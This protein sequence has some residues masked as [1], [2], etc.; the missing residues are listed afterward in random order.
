MLRGA[1][2][3]LPRDYPR[4]TGAFT[5]SPF[6]PSRFSMLAAAHSAACSSAAIARPPRHIFTIRYPP[7]IAPMRLP[8]DS[9]VFCSAMPFVFFD[10]FTPFHF[11]FSQQPLICFF[12][13]TPMPALVTTPPAAMLF[14]LRRCAA[15]L[16]SFPPAAEA[17]L[18]PPALFIAALPFFRHHELTPRR[19]FFCPHFQFFSRCFVFRQ[20]FRFSAT[21]MPPREMLCSSVVMAESRGAVRRGCRAVQAGWLYAYFYFLCRRARSAQCASA[22]F[23]FYFFV[24][25]VA[26]GAF[27]E[28][29][30]LRGLLTPRCRYKGAGRRLSHSHPSALPPRRH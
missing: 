18:M 19:Y 14:F 7:L 26:G 20:P 22:R 25:S 6:F 4:L 24:V 23:R 27:R 1:A 16:S 9:A 15:R 28:R 2:A 12:F 11:A 21:P 8:I 3:R 29:G 13:I 10:I 30:A 17:M 5:D